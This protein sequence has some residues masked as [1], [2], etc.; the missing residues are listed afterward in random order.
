MASTTLKSVL[1]IIIV[2]IITATIYTFSSPLSRSLSSEY[3]RFAHNRNTGGLDAHS[4]DVGDANG[5]SLIIG[6]RD[7]PHIRT[8]ECL[9]IRGKKRCGGLVKREP[10]ESK[11][12]VFIYQ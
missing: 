11:W 9:T 3:Q 5:E 2:A 1:L 6:G 10:L 8:F 7:F 4:D 12:N